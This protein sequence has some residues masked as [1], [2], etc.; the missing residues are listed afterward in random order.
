MT[1]Y[2]TFIPLVIM[3]AGLTP[4]VLKDK[5]IGNKQ[6]IIMMIIIASVG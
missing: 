1:E 4:I 5:Y 6:R 2:I 3:L